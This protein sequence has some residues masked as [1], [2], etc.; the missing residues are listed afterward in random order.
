[1]MRTILTAF[2]IAGALPAQYAPIELPAEW[3]FS[4]TWGLKH[5]Y[6]IASWGDFQKLNEEMWYLEFQ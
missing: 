5:A 6:K 4:D 2:L 3:T 1:M